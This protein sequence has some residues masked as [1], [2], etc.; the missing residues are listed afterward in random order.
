VDMENIKSITL[1]SILDKQPVWF[2]A[3]VVL[4]QDRGIMAKGLFDYQSLLGVKYEMN[5]AERIM[6]RETTA[7]HAMTFIGVDM[8]NDKP[9]KW[10][11]ENSWGSGKGQN[12]L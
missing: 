4:D 9:V 7:N 2:G 12:G 11:V 3:D 6:S 1:K 8:Q 5:K 10:L